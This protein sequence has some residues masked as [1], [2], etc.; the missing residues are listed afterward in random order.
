MSF[1]SSAAAVDGCQHG[2]RLCFATLEGVFFFETGKCKQPMIPPP[3][4]RFRTAVV[5]KFGPFDVSAQSESLQRGCDCSDA[6]LCT[7][8]GK[9]AWAC[10]A[11]NSVQELNVKVYQGHHELGCHREH[12]ASE[13]ILGRFMVDEWLL[14]FLI[15]SSLVC[16]GRYK[17]F[18]APLIETPGR[19]SRLHRI[20]LMI[21]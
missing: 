3:P 13:L 20:G 16:L 21:A 17:C 19:I 2:W 10:D 12:Y 18:I 4:S 9:C 14:C 6:G 11:I 1:L 8:G 7:L 5:D 15:W